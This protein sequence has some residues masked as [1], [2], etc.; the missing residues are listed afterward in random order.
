MRGSRSIS[1]ADQSEDRGQ[2]QKCICA[3][4]Y[5]SKFAHGKSAVYLEKTSARKPWT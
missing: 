3:Q 5:N 1:G 2:Q 4:L